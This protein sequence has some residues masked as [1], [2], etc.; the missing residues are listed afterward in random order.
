MKAAFYQGDRTVSVGRCTPVDPGP[1][2]VQIRV[3]HAGICG[4]DLHIW[5]GAMDK[6]VKTPAVLG[7]EMSGEIAQIGPGVQ[8]WSEG[9]PVT[10]MPLDF[11]ANPPAG[12]SHIAEF[13]KFMGIDTPGAFQSYWTVPAST[14]FRLP[15]GLSLAHGALIEPLAVACHDVRLGAIQPGE[16]VVVIGGGPIGM[17]VAMAAQHAGGKVV[18]SEVNPF[19][20]AKA[21]ELGLEAVNP[22]ETDL[23]QLVLDRTAGRGADAVFEV[24][25]SKPAAA[26]MTDLPR[27]RG[28][29][30][31]VAVYA[32]KPEVDLFRFFWREL[33]LRGARVYEAED[34]DEAI[35]IAASGELPL[36]RLVT[37]TT[38]LEGLQ[39]GFEKMDAGGECM[40]IL[41][42]VRA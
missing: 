21:K 11:G 23:K 42:D 40:K 20:V 7:H 27:I 1:G 17:L 3:S 28:R 4:T 12:H 31:L 36:D 16:H 10:V 24:S 6:R 37:E 38:G 22:L 14:L 33:E 19:R 9:D 30:V 18:V 15:E 35:R 41:I 26:V 32:F 2:E 25:G 5:H 8:G 39:S 29:V 34:Y 13:M